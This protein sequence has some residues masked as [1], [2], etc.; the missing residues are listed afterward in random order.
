[1]GHVSVTAIFEVIKM[2]I[3]PIDTFHRPRDY[4]RRDAPLVQ[5]AGKTVLY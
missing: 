1:M 4:T 3:Q 5:C 2:P